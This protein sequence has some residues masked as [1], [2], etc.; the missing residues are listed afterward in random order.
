MK[1]LFCCI[2]IVFLS[3]CLASVIFFNK[4]K[5]ERYDYEY[6]YLDLTFEQKEVQRFIYS[7]SKVHFYTIDNPG[8]IINPY[9]LS[10]LTAVMFFSLEE[11][12]SVKV[13]INDEFYKDIVSKDFIIP[14]VY[15]IEDYKNKI[16]LVYKD[17]TYTYYIE[18]EKINDVYKHFDK[19]GNSKL[20]ASGTKMKN[21]MLNEDGKVIWYLDL[22]TQ[23]LIEPIS[24]DTFLIGTE[25]SR[26]KNGVS[27]FTGLYEMDYLG[28]IIKR[29]DTPYGYHHEIKY[30]GDNRALILGTSDYELDT[31][32]ELDL[33]TG[34]SKNVINI[35]DLLCAGNE[36]LRDYLKKVP[37]GMQVNSID[38]L[39]GNVL[40]SLKNLNTIIEFNYENKQ[41]NYI[42]SNNSV[43]KEN[44]KEYLCDAN[45][46][47]YG[48]HNAKYVS[49]EEI[50]FF[51]NGY[52]YLKYEGHVAEGVVLN[53]NT[54][55][56]SVYK[57]ED[58][59]SYGFG[60]ISKY[61]DNVLVNYPYMYERIPSNVLDYE[62]YYSNIVSIKNNKMKN[63]IK[64]N[65]NIYRVKEHEIN[66]SDKYVESKY[67]YFS[68]NLKEIDT[69]IK[70]D[71]I[72]RETIKVK[73]N[74]IEILASFDMSDVQVFFVG[75]KSYSLK[76]LG[77]VTYF[78]LP[79]GIYQIYIQVGDQTYKYPHYFNF[80]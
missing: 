51:N 11:E 62:D 7:K 70:G 15:L 55:K 45:L 19:K 37:Y 68:D 21:F 60:S 29:F 35:S 20:L 39:N 6:P 18:T 4:L 3:S 2:V 80:L 44:L 69:K 63:T 64:I 30:I 12:G 50:S 31:L 48:T 61:G 27:V 13:F 41:I 46:N 54:G 56:K 74:S 24:R 66:M 75:E 26:L 58:K 14:I 79:N 34:I 5:L 38:Y 76:Y 28:K 8:I 25:E 23:G 52:D 32:Y 36:G 67:Q 16:D 17:K 49:E 10:P 71:N 78:E 57:Y 65:D 33:N 59:Y 42:L 53:I 77:T 1:K 72:F 9:K 22:D 47:F 73:N 40:L 43:I